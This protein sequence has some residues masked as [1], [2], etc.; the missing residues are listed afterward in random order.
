MKCKKII[1]IIILI[2]IVIISGS[3]ITYALLTSNK[4]INSTN[5]KIAKFIFNTN[6]SDS[7]SISLEDLKPGDEK[8]YSFEVTN[9]KNNIT[10]DVNINYQITIKTLHFIPININLYKVM[11]EKDEL[12]LTCDETANRNDKN[13]LECLSTIEQLSYTN[14]SNDSY[15]LVINFPSQY[16]TLEYTDLVDYIDLK[17]SSWQKIES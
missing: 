10:S 15:K 11:D 8:E 1:L 3:Q 14:S 13:E 17:I 16:N 9:N 12:V 2:L 4:N 7:I 6:K 5:Q